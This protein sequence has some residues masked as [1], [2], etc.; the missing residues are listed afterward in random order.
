M[1]WFDVAVEIVCVRL[2]FC[3]WCMCWLP[4]P[5]LS[6]A[7]LCRLLVDH[8]L[9]LWVVTITKHIPGTYIP[10]IRAGEARTPRFCGSHGM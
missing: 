2:S 6:P 1:V 10:G 7:G 8:T 3:R 9:E 5:Y 4:K